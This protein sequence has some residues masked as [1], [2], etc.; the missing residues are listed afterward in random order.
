MINRYFSPKKNYVATDLQIRDLQTILETLDDLANMDSWH[1]GRQFYELY[2][3]DIEV[4]LEKFLLSLEEVDLST[5][6]P[7]D[8]VATGGDF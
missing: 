3:F 5:P 7:K 2:G 8:R 4:D 6:E 1:Q